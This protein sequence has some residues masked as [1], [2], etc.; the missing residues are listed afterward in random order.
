MPSRVAKRLSDLGIC[1][2]RDAELKIANKEV[3]INGKIAEV[4]DSVSEYDTIKINDDKIKN[5]LPK[6]KIYLMN[7]PAGYITSN[8][9]P[10]GRKTVFDLIPEN[11][12]RLISVGRL[13]YNTEGLMIF[14]NRGDFAREL[15]L[16][17]SEIA[18]EYRVKVFGDLDMDKISE[19]IKKGLVID[20]IKY[21]KVVIYPERPVNKEKGVAN[22]WIRVI[23]D[24]GKNREVRKIMDYFGLQ[25]AKLQ[26]LRFGSFKLREHLESAQITEFKL[27]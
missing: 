19:N 20:K 3:W 23:I 13:D 11:L 25:V 15:E 27:K 7:K 6:L 4:T 9:D 24:E 22:N 26:R 8:R 10:Q 14:T 16:P 2:R 12:G 1:S 18:R 21:R 17:S 5:K